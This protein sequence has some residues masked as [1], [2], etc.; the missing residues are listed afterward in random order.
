MKVDKYIESLDTLNKDDNL[1]N[2]FN[3]GMT[4]LDKKK[5]DKALTIF[6][7]LK[8]KKPCKEVY[9]NLG[10]IYREKGQFEVAFKYFEKAA[11][12]N[13]P[14]WNG[15]YLIEP[16]PLALSNLGA[17]LYDKEEN[18]DLA[19]EYFIA[20]YTIDRTIHS[21][22]WN[23]GVVGLRQFI[24]GVPN[25]DIAKMWK[26]YEFRFKSNINVVAHKEHIEWKVGEYHLDEDI[27]ILGDQGHGDFLMFARYIPY[28][29]KFFRKVYVQPRPGMQEFFTDLYNKE[30]KYFVPICN[31]GQLLDYIPNG[32]WLEHKRVDKVDGEFAVGCVWQGSKDYGHDRWRSCPKK[33]FDTLDVKKYTFAPN[34]KSYEYLEGENWSDTIK[35][36]EKVDL[37]ITI[38][39]AMAHLCGCLGKECWVIMPLHFSDWRWGSRFNGESN[40]WY[41]SVK[42]IRNY[43]NWDDV[44]KEIRKKLSGRSTNI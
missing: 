16:C 18:Y 10:A 32:E 13:L 28:V 11:E 31:L 17:L 44:F 30:A 9:L 39:T 41:P 2:L 33:Y 3:E 5:Y 40:K 36:L 14:Y 22:A 20:S 27:V 24:D 35:N 7:I 26:F 21:S 34:E 25:I 37:V 29:N 23:I 43:G 15:M 19:A 42:V 38:D 8:S 6:N 1:I 12:L 4:V